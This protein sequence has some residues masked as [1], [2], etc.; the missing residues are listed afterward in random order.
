MRFKIGL[1]I[2]VVVY[3]VIYLNVAADRDWGV[4]RYRRNLE[5]YD[6]KEFLTY[7]LL[8]IIPILFIVLGTRHNLLKENRNRE[9]RISLVQKKYGVSE[10]KAQEIATLGNSCP[11]CDG[12]D[13]YL[14]PFTITQNITSVFATTSHTKHKNVRI[15]ESCEVEFVPRIL[16]N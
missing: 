16:L 14:Q 11:K 2:T 7:W 15:C 1:A 4:W 8:G 12:Y 3:S 13:Y 6:M 5:F 9:Q 10:A